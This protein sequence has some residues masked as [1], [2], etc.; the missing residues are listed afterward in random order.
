[1][2]TIKEAMKEDTVRESHFHPRS[3]ATE[4]E[5]SPVSTKTKNK[6][7]TALTPLFKKTKQKGS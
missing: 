7:T 4:T 6:K 3:T 2:S 1:M 5:R